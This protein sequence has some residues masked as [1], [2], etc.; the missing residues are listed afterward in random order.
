MS[1]EIEAVYEDGVLKPEKPL[2]LQE[3]QRVTVSVKPKSE[4]PPSEKRPSSRIRQSAG[5]LRWTGDPDV[6]R[7]IAEDPQFGISE[8]P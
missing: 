3:H 6:L 1:L 2:P 5:L 7:K 4:K 8:S